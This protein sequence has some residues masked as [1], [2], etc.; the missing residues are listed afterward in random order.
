VA[1][2]QT[3]SDYEKALLANPGWFT[4]L[5][6]DGWLRRLD[7]EG[8]LGCKKKKALALMETAVEQGLFE[9]GST[10]VR[11]GTTYTWRPSDR[12]RAI[13]ELRSAETPPERQETVSPLAG[14]AVVAFIPDAEPELLDVAADLYLEVRRVVEEQGTSRSVY[15]LT[16][17]DG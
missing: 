12:A 1:V 2:G 8:A 9:S 11:G 6:W 17:V 7:V 14:L 10:T 5:T 13:S 15:R 3:L 4:L 16:P